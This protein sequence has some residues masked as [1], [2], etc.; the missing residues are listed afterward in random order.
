MPRPPNPRARAK[1]LVAGLQLISQQGVNATGVKEITGLAGVPKGSF[2]SYFGS[3]D[4]FVVDVLEYCWAEL[5]RDVGPL[6]DTGH[7][8][9]ERLAAYFRAIAGDYERNSYLLG[10][11]IG[12]LAL[13]LAGSG[14][15]VTNRLRAIL[16]C[17]E[18]RI[19]AV[20]AHGDT[21]ERRKVAALI[22][23]AWE[24]AVVRSKIDS[25]D[26]PYARFEAVTLPLLTA[27]CSESTRS[28]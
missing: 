21:D 16:I 1:L 4:E 13:E 2:Y 5:E 22:I 24:G 14:G 3:K 12:N 6:L 10:C 25:S 19:A 15:V 23:E 11:L 27:L 26:E 28:P 8:P 20:F 18:D 17:W 9:L 7:P